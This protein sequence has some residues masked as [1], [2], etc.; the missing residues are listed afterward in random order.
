MINIFQR[1]TFVS[2]FFLPFIF[3]IPLSSCSEKDKSITLGANFIQSDTRLVR[4]DTFALELSTIVFDSLPSSGNKAALCGSY[5]DP[6]FGKIYTRSN[7]QFTYPSTFDITDSDIYDSTFLILSHN[8]YSYGDTTLPFTIGAYQLDGKI[9]PGENNYMYTTSPINWNPEA[10]GIKTF[11][12]MPVSTDSIAIRLS[13]ELGKALFKDLWFRTKYSYGESDILDY[14]KGIMIRAVN[15]DASAVLGFTVSDG[16]PKIRIYSHRIG[17]VQVDNEVEFPL[18]STDLQFNQIVSN[19]SGTPLAGLKTQREDIS[20]VS[21]GNK[22]FIQCGA[23]LMTK[24]KFPS[25]EQILLMQNEGVFLSAILKICPSKESYKDKKLPE[26]L[27]LFST[28][29]YNRLGDQLFDASEKAIVGTLNSDYQ[30]NE[31]INYSFDI[32]YFLKL[33]FANNYF[34]SE[35]GILLTFPSTDV[36]TKTDKMQVETDPESGNAPKLLVYYMF[37]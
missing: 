14:F 10:L 24:I 30:Y 18:E 33:E 28:D 12:P 34:D 20:S 35:H 5:T 6:Y 27:V 11:Y 4:I 32:S 16:A 15:D 2:R 31:N 9:D 21:T 22:S 17:Q 36:Y 7:F 13:D 37:Y 19:R 8:N 25:M 29:K 23:G 3:L 1:S 26:T